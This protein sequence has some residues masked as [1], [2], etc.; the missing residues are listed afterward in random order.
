MD[1]S[2][3]WGNMIR[4]QN[5]TL[6]QRD[7][8]HNETGGAAPLKVRIHG[9]GASL[10]NENSCMQ[11]HTNSASFSAMTHLKHKTKAEIGSETG[12]HK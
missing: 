11:K 5:N 2:E 4:L 3:H 1:C 8:Q 6:I 10:L 9:N 7:N 12:F